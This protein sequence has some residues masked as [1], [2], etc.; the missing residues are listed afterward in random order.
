MDDLAADPV[1][2]VMEALAALGNLVDSIGDLA[3][4][5]FFSDRKPGLE[6]SI[7]DRPNRLQY[8]AELSRADMFRFRTTFKVVVSTHQTHVLR[9]AT[10]IE[11]A[12]PA[13]RLSQPD[14]V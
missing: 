1:Q 3:N 12:A 13:P 8:G 14:V 2:V 6:V 9:A 11:V 5:A 7:A 4:D 10:Y